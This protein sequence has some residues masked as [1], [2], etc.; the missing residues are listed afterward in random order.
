[1]KL[2]SATKTQTPLYARAPRSPCAPHF[3]IVSAASGNHASSAHNYLKLILMRRRGSSSAC[4]L[5][6][7]VSIR[8][9]EPLTFHWCSAYIDVLFI[10]AV[11]SI[12]RR[13]LRKISDQCSACITTTGVYVFVSNCQNLRGKLRMLL[14]NRVQK[15]NSFRESALKIAHTRSTSH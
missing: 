10:N 15:T 11:V 6:F 9:M 4:L 14:G 13:W 1:M 12:N 3:Q 7:T 8:Q 2:M 5:Q